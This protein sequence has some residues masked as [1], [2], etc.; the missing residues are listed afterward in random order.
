MDILLMAFDAI[1]S[2]FGLIVDLGE[3]FLNFWAIGGAIAG[4]FVWLIEF[5]QGI[6]E[7]FG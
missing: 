6:A 4:F 1:A 5:F 7:L 2:I 3:F